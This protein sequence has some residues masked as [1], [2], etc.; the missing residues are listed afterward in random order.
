MSLVLFKVVED[1]RDRAEPQASPLQK[2]I[3]ENEG[4]T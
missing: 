3:E 4:E 2:A 1:H